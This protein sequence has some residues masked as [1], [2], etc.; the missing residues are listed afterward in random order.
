M[1]NAGMAD[2]VSDRARQLPIL[3]A[4]G[5]EPIAGVV[6]PLVGEAY[7]DA[8]SRESPQLFD[9]AIQLLRSFALEEFDDRRASGDELR[10][11]APP[12]IQRI[13]QDCCLGI[14]GIPAILRCAHLSHGS[15]VSEGKQRCPI[16][17]S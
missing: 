8:V 13:A 6:P 5:T 1:V 11:I 2:A 14:A 16:F 9:Q 3:V 17:R 10:L 15:L 7:R 4:V 12:G